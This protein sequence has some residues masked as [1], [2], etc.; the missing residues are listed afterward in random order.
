MYS[1]ECGPT[2]RP[3]KYEIHYTLGKTVGTTFTFKRCPLH[4]RRELLVACSLANHPGRRAATLNVLGNVPVALAA[5]TAAPALPAEATLATLAL[6]MALTV[7]LVLGPAALAAAIALA[8]KLV[9]ATLGAR[10]LMVTAAASVSPRVAATATRGAPPLPAAGRA[11]VL[12]LARGGRRA[13][14]AAVRV[15]RVRV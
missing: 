8:L 5:A 13:G 12:P 10:A 11:M 7:V 3:R 1:Q 4:P 15:A 9:P 14:A 2:Q 6:L